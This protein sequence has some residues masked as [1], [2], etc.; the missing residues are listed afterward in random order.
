MITFANAG[1]ATRFMMDYDGYL[2]GDL[3]QLNKQMYIRVKKSTRDLI[4][5]Y[6]GRDL[7]A[8][9]PRFGED[10]WNYHPPVSVRQENF[11][12]HWEEVDRRFAAGEDQYARKY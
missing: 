12:P 4:P 2:G 6:G 11:N 10:V 9:R 5:G 8:G 3:N 7:M 1:L